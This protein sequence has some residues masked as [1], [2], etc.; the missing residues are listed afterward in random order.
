[1]RHS[2]EPRPTLSDDPVALRPIVL[3]GEFPLKG[4]ALGQFTDDIIAD[5]TSRRAT[6]RI[7]DRSR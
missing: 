7:Y 3:S 6:C 1:V 2:I 5:E 4:E